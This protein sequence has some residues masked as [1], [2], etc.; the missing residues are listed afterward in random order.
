MEA[1]LN[2]LRQLQQYDLQIQ[3]I[4]ARNER[5]Q[6]SLDDLQALHTSLADS[7][8]AQ[9][10]QLDDTRALMRNKEIE[11]EENLDRY[12]QSKAKLSSVA[13][14]KQYNALEKEMDTLKKMRAQLE[15]ERDTLRENVENFEADVAEKQAKVDEL[16]AQI[17]E[18][19]AAVD[20]E[21]SGAS[22]AI[23]DLEKQRTQLKGDLPKQMFRRYE[24]ILSRGRRPAVTACVGGVC[25]GCNMTVP[26]QLFN[27]LQMSRRLIQCPSCQRILFH[28]S[29]L[30]VGA[31]A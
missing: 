25:T 26:P 28:A 14:T 31:N 16:A 11:L 22:G 13:N 23:S 1:Q 12:N 18:E 7:L 17:A 3:E 8:Q 29:D 19:Q 6:E 15:E 9:K 5:L 21:T 10:Q 2:L 20:K 27:E 30:E 4:Q 24:F